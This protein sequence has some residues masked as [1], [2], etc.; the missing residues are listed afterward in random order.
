MHCRRWRLKLARSA[1]WVLP[2]QVAVVVLGGRQDGLLLPPGVLADWA[3][4]EPCLLVPDPDGPGRQAAIDRALSD[5][6]LRGR[7]A[8]IGPSVPLGHAAMSLRWA[9][10]AL[11]VIS[12]GILIAALATVR[13]MPPPLFRGL[14]IAAAVVAAVTLVFLWHPETS[15]H[16]RE[17]AE[18]D[19]TSADS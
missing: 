5:R 3:G 18:L 16:C 19:R 9:R 12:V 4:P 1:A 8:A 10:H 2:A 13:T 11:A 17:A 7:P 14:I 6:A 15:R